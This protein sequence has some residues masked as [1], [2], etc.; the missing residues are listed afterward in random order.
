LTERIAVLVDGQL[1]F[2]DAKTAFGV[3]RYGTDHVVALI[4]HANAGRSVSEWITVPYE[5]P[6]VATL[7]TASG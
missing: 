1:T 2:G 5:V 7:A 4:D 6:I 3:I